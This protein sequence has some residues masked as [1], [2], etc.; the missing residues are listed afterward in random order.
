MMN[1]IHERNMALE[2]KVIVAEDESRSLAE[3]LE[4][5]A[6][7]KLAYG[8]SAKQQD[9]LVT[10][11][12]QAIVEERRAGAEFN[13]RIIGSEVHN[14][15]LMASLEEIN[16]NN[17]S[18][19]AEILRLNT[20]DSELKIH[21]SQAIDN[22]IQARSLLIN[23]ET[24]GITYS[25]MDQRVQ[26]EIYTLEYE[27]HKVTESV[28]RMLEIVNQMR[29]LR[30]AVKAEY[31]IALQ[32]QKFVA[33]KLNTS[34]SELEAIQEILRSHQAQIQ[35]LQNAMRLH[36]KAFDA[37]I[38]FHANKLAFLAQLRDKMIQTHADQVEELQN[39]KREMLSIDREFE[40]ANSTKSHWAKQRD[41]LTAYLTRVN[42]RVAQ[43]KQKL[44]F[45]KSHCAELERQCQ[46][47]MDETKQL[48]LK[49]P[50]AQVERA[51]LKS[52]FDVL[53]AQESENIRQLHAQLKELTEQVEGL[54]SKCESDR[55]RQQFYLKQKTKL[56][57]Y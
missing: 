36:Q 27:L 2:R 5:V 31:K 21:L 10:T 16:S 3:S 13:V 24:V 57:F 1:D 49:L 52:R 22:C 28:D 48:E 55:V 56:A 23:V 15:R 20:F 45:D 50:S 40:K 7:S 51:S 32:K 30:T 38:Q 37:S 53:H 4:Q 6:R 33:K 43:A 35:K 19:T 8:N 18:T 46:D 34:T 54:E 44:Q 26:K 47:L 42:E 29:S 17:D 9:K 25:Q 11:L 14:T 39:L 41:T 12:K